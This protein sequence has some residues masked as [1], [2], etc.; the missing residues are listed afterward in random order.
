MPELRLIMLDD[1][2]PPPEIIN[3]DIFT[4]PM[5]ETWG[6]PQVVM[7][8]IGDD[9]TKQCGVFDS[10]I[11]RINK[12]TAQLARY[13][14]RGLLDGRGINLKGLPV[15]KA[16]GPEGGVQ[17]E[18]S[19]KHH[20]PAPSRR[21]V[22]RRPSSVSSKIPA[23]ALA[24]ISPPVPVAFH[25][26]ATTGV[27]PG[28]PPHV[29]PM[30][31][32]QT[33]RSHEPTPVTNGSQTTPPSVRVDERQTPRHHADDA[34]HHDGTRG[35]PYYR[36]HAAHA[37]EYNEHDHYSYAAAPDENTRH[38]QVGGDMLQTHTSERRG[39]GGQPLVSRKVLSE[40][41]FQG[42]LDG[43]QEP[44]FRFER[45][46]TYSRS[47]N[48]VGENST[49]FAPAY[50]ASF[51]YAPQQ[52]IYTR[53]EDDASYGT[54]RVAPTM[55]YNHAH[56]RPSSASTA[57][58]ESIGAI[59]APYGTVEVVNRDI[60]LGHSFAASDPAPHVQF[61]TYQYQDRI[62]L[63]VGRS[64]NPQQPQAAGWTPVE[65]N[66]PQVPAYCRPSYSHFLAEGQVPVHDDIM[67]APLAQCPKLAI[68]LHHMDANLF[69]PQHAN[70]PPLAAL[71]AQ[72]HAHGF[73]YNLE[74]RE[75]SNPPF[76]SQHDHAFAVKGSSPYDHQGAQSQLPY[77]A[78]SVQIPAP[79]RQIPM[80]VAQT[81]DLLGHPT[82]WQ[83][84]QA[85]HYQGAVLQPGPRSTIVN[86]G[87]VMAHPSALKLGRAPLATNSLYEREYVSTGG[88]SGDF[89]P[90]HDPTSMDGSS[91]YA[92]AQANG[93]QAS[94]PSS[95]QTAAF[96]NA[97]SQFDPLARYF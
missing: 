19:A 94:S 93:I 53:I 24:E 9:A 1:S 44:A 92:F 4:T 48:L 45:Q 21:P 87:S 47:L 96:D 49:E 68:G 26:L 20:P 65:F 84:T 23:T 11:K 66:A 74:L 90:Q 80:W 33:P 30:D 95:V 69:H 10:N 37:L 27:R 63:P 7:Q 50:R 22:K 91:P 86:D 39:Y 5:S 52:H 16:K 77:G 46:T 97:V 15:P 43:D 41:G 17:R 61:S 12:K 79:S 62:L 64:P 57:S 54:P 76:G 67:S 81:S 28:A 40:V 85:A 75:F 29:H 42:I 13:V 14:R 3:T 31:D 83:P 35:H 82:P 6:K 70:I 2:T 72:A 73:G 36:P 71:H 78:G 51:N 25:P 58:S 88:L 8:N 18:T 38:G 55:Y 60:D 59:V 32:Y 89:V 34:R 56:H